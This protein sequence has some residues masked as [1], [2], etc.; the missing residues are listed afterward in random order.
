[1]ISTD[2]FHSVFLILN[3]RYVVSDIE[4]VQLQIKRG[5]DGGE[6]SGKERQ[7][8]SAGL[9]GAVGVKLGVGGSNGES[10]TR[11]SLH[12]PDLPQH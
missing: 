5:F 12:H 6:K 2:P 1:M 3:T 9:F 10:G 4:V 8:V 11:P 7:E